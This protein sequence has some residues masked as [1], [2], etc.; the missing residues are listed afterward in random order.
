MNL[1]NNKNNKCIHCGKTYT[2]KSSLQNHT[3]LCHLLK[4]T[5]RE[6]K[7][8]DEENSELPNYRDL[9]KIIGMLA[10]AN[11]KLE[12]KVHSME[13]WVNK[14]KKKINILDWLNANITPTKSWEQMLD[15]I[16]LNESHIDHII[17]NN[18]LKT[19]QVIFEEWFTISD[20]GDSPH[21]LQAFS[22]KQNV[23]YIYKSNFQTATTAETA[24]TAA[25]WSELTKEE[26]ICFLYKIDRKIQQ[27]VTK[28]RKKYAEKMETSDKYCT[29]YNKIIY[30]VNSISFRDDS[31][32]SKVK[33]IL[34]NIIKREM[35][36]YI[37]YEFINPV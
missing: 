16:V 14:S 15:P 26:L 11:Q 4:Q 18:A 30:K 36:N 35:K 23:F 2:R 24:T 27:E 37:E 1:D 13:K 5:K 7:I 8:D 28:W 29:L 20:Q 22:Q 3:L 31:T 10:V 33:T 17:E 6:D 19:Y 32:L 9:V 34:F 12:E 25:A 21:P